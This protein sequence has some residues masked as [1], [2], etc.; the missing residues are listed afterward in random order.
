VEP[1]HRCRPLS[2]TGGKEVQAPPS[3]VP[4][5]CVPSVTAGEL[6]SEGYRLRPPH[7][8]KVAHGGASTKRE[9][10]AERGR[11]RRV[12]HRR[13]PIG[14]ALAALLCYLIGGTMVFTLEMA[15]EVSFR[16]KWDLSVGFSAV[17]PGHRCRPLSITGGKEVQAPP[18]AV[19]AVCVPSLTAGVLL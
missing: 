2:I 5:V 17:E 13:R 18:S 6:L 15:A 10:K 7:D 16:L 1:G 14:L 8:R 19:P 11:M 9:E 3:A 4:A 12:P